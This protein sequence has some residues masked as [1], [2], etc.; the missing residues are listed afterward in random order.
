MF[1][2]VAPNFWRPSSLQAS[3]KLE[4]LSMRNQM[5]HLGGDGLPHLALLA[6]AHSWAPRSLQRRLCRNLQLALQV[7]KRTRRLLMD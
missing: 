1:C 5:T 3:L 4:I 2:T 6:A 7:L